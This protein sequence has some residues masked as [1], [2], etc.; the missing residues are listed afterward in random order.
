[1]LARSISL[2][3]LFGACHHAGAQG[4]PE[5]ASQAVQ[6]RVERVNLG[7]IVSDQNGQLVEGLKREDFQVFDN[8]SEQPLTGFAAIEEPAQV[9]LLIEA[10]PAV[11]LLEG[12]HLQAANSL[13]NGLSADDRV[14]VA[15]YAEAAARVL[16]FTVDKQTAAAALERLQFNLGFG[17]LNLSSSVSETLE[18]LASVPGKKS[19]V[20]LS[21]GFDTTPSV[22][23]T[24]VIQQLRVSDVR[25]L[26]ISLAGGLESPAPSKKK[27]TAATN[28]GRTDEEFGRAN[29]LLKQ[30]AES[31][32]GRAYFPA[33]AKEFD[34]AYGQIAQ[35][36]RHEYSL[37]FAPPAHDG[38]VH[39]IEVRINSPQSAAG[40]AKAGGYRVAHRQAY[41]APT[42]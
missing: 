19:I 6:V 14:A 24:K 2:A 13:L 9:L 32:G 15:R 35:L 42:P 31:S 40:K 27:R 23:I 8:G 18:W 41:L 10:G 33:S 30:M 7:V 29:E 4:N 36:V 21:T 39:A 22:G 28:P 12:G 16:D 3:A 38:L 20:L 5:K 37:A 34:A 17:A 26:A 25:L 11:Y 1:L